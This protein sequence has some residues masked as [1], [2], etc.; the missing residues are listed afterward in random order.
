M[1]LVFI[2]LLFSN[3]FI[4]SADVDN[5]QP[6]EL[7]SDQNEKQFLGLDFSDT[8]KFNLTV[9]DS[10]KNHYFINE[11]KTLVLNEPCVHSMLTQSRYKE[12]YT[13]SST[14]EIVF[15]S[16]TQES[17]KKYKL[18]E[19]NKSFLIKQLK[20]DSIYQ[21]KIVVT[22][23]MKFSL[24][25]LASYE[26]LA[27]YIPYHSEHQIY[28][29]ENLEKTFHY[30]YGSNYTKNSLEYK[31]D[32]IPQIYPVSDLITKYFNEDSTSP[33]LTNK[34]IIVVFKIILQTEGESVNLQPIVFLSGKDSIIKVSEMYLNKFFQFGIEILGFAYFLIFFTIWLQRKKERIY[35]YLALY[36]I[37]VFTYKILSIYFNLYGLENSLSS[38]II[39]I[40]LFNSIYYFY[41]KSV[42]LVVDTGRMKLNKYILSSFFV[43][44]IAAII[45]VLSFF[46]LKKDQDFVDVKFNQILMDWILDPDFNKT[47]AR[48][49]KY[50]YEGRIDIIELC[51]QKA[52]KN[53]ESYL[54]DF[55]NLKKKSEE[56]TEFKYSIENIFFKDKESSL[57][58]IESFQKFYFHREKILNYIFLISI[59]FI[60]GTLFTQIAIFKRNQKNSNLLYRLIFVFLTFLI[61][62]KLSLQPLNSFI[63]MY[64]SVEVLFIYLIFTIVQIV[65]YVRSKYQLDNLNIHLTEKIEEIESLNIAYERF[66]PEQ[67]I[68]M[69]NKDSIIK[70]GLGDQIQKEM[71]ILFSDIRSFTRLSEGMSPKENFDFINAYLKRIGPKIGENKGF[72]DKYIGD[73]IMA[74]FPEQPEDAVDAGIAM[75]SEL[76]HYNQ[77]RKIKSREALSIGIGIHTG[78]LIMGIVGEENRLNGTV[79]SD[80][81][82]LASRIEGLTKIYAA[83]LLTSD[84]TFSG[85]QNKN[86]YAYRIVDTVKVKGKKEPVTVIEI[87]NGNS[88]R[89]IDLKL[90]TKQQLE[91]GIVQYQSKDFANAKLSFETVLK[92]DPKDK[93]AE[94]YYRRSDYYE[95]YGVPP[96]WVGVES[97]DQK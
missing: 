15:N 5:I 24:Y 27:I 69:L 75:L 94:I 20:K 28:L 8:E 19:K 41:S 26:N 91:N 29:K 77:Y 83:S 52:G 11:N 46:P 43:S 92:K 74:L 17:E 81:V 4:H 48:D 90:S 95:K 6:I 67:F 76:Y 68:E 7:S 53:L 93:A 59:I 70:V 54:I 3:Q 1:V 57:F 25:D 9:Q 42:C 71:S 55:M 47:N 80:S 72:I 88:P 51:E 61:F 89:I 84:R 97:L 87:L 96:E 23:K 39:S 62:L 82:N 79:I 66:V 50:S 65:Q 18:I 38:V 45:V 58:R 21:C 63:F 33:E 16:Y 36:S 64:T 10:E 2:L 35:L 85:I 56:L 14:P 49:C 30:I 37:F 13:L 32:L 31:L 73:A 86:K 60:F 34:E 12:V 22:F 44:L 78:N 40:L